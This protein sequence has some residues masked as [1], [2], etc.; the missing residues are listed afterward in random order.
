MKKTFIISYDIAA[1]D[2]FDYKKIYEY[3][4]AYGM[5]AKIT[6]STWAIV[7]EKKATEVRD[8]IVSIL[9]AESRI[10]VVKSGGI[11]AWR[12]AIGRNEWLKK[13]L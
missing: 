7:T 12:N 13:Y 10:F 9:P 8:E 4:K 11:S 2:A 1:G 5:W 6:E 3:F